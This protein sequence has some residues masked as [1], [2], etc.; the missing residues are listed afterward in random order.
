M[1]GELLRLTDK[2]LYCPLGDFYIDPKG[3]VEKAVVTHAHADHAYRGHRE[4]LVAGSSVGVLKARLGGQIKVRGI[5]F[6]ERFTLGGATLSFHPA[7]HILGSAQVR[8]EAAGEVW[9]VS[10][11][12]KR[13]PD[14]SCEPFSVVP[15]DTFVTE[16][17]FGTP[18]YVWKRGLPIGQ[19]IHDWWMKNR[20]A[21]LQSLL[22]GYSL[23][24]SQRLLAE[25]KP[26]AGGERVWIHPTLAE[27]TECY[28]AEGIALCDTEVLDEARMR[29]GE[30]AP[31]SLIV[32]P[33]QVERAGWGERLGPYVSA[34]ASGWQAPGSRFGDREG[35][36]VSDHADWPALLKTIE[37]TGA[38]RVYV[39]HRGT[40]ALVRELRARLIEAYPV[41]ALA[42]RREVP[43]GQACLL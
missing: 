6:G 3:G 34:F 35:F 16:A 38:Q 29:E 8:I 13:E 39:Q 26:Y 19:E 14:P 36:V 4:Y 43:P 23:G 32:A 20:A 5:P 40:G 25:L 11:D 22:L 42:V 31:G 24:K 41:K 12:F 27:I 21:G 17:T 37:E 10:G 7:G 9:V 28:R 2:G 33:P 1:K 18:A 15:C 30:V